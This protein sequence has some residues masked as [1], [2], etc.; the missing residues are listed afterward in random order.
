MLLDLLLAGE[1]HKLFL[2][3]AMVFTQVVL[4]PEVLCTHT[5]HTVIAQRQSP[6]KQFQKKEGVLDLTINQA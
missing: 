5:T 1:D 3:A 6:Q 2:Q 4:V